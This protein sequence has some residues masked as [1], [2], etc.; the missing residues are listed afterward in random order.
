MKLSSS[1]VLK[2]S[3]IFFLCSGCASI[4]SV[5]KSDYVVYFNRPE[6]H[7]YIQLWPSA[8]HNSEAAAQD[9]AKI[10]QGSER[11]RTIRRP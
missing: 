4:Q 10:A 2:V 11:M 9:I 1:E 8:F 5:Y 6:V 7:H 3:L